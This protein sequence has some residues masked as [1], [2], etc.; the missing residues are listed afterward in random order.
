MLL[1]MYFNRAVLELQIRCLNLTTV[2][3]NTT[4]VVANKHT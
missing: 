4:R 3:N 1:I 2:T